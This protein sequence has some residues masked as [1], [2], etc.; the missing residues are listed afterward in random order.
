MSPSVAFRLPLPELTRKLLRSP[1]ASGAVSVESEIALK[2]ADTASLC[3]NQYPGYLIA[4]IEQ[5]VRERTLRAD[6]SRPEALKR[7]WRIL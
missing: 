6:V 4:I 2:S 5:Q 7:V 1:L 3:L